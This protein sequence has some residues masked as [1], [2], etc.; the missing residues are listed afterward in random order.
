MRTS[1][2]VIALAGVVTAIVLCQPRLAVG[3]AAPAPPAASQAQSGDLAGEEV[4][5]VEQTIVYAEG[6]AA[7]NNAF[8]TIVNGLKSIYAFLEKENIGATGPAMT[9]YMSTDDSGFKFRVAVPVAQPPAGLAA[10]LSAGKSP[11][12]K[13]LKYVHRGPYDTLDATYEAITNQ[14]DEKGLE[15]QDLFVE[16]YRTDP[17]T[18]APDNLVVE[19]FVPIK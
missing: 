12:G 6:S 14:L 13:A 7:W 15:A 19:V 16:V 17:R 2:C 4:T 9:I 10:G 3:Q 5:M 8:E 11:A 18:T 1:R